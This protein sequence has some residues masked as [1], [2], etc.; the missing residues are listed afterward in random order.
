MIKNH[1]GANF[2]SHSVDQSDKVR[3]LMAVSEADVVCPIDWTGCLAWSSVKSMLSTVPPILYL[4]FRVFSL[5][6]ADADERDWY[7]EKEQEAVEQACMVVALSEKDKGVLSQLM[8]GRVIPVEVLLPPLRGDMKQLAS[9]NY[10]DLKQYMPENVT[11]ALTNRPPES[12]CL[13]TCIAR[14]SPEKHIENFVKFVEAN[15]ELFKQHDWIPLLAGSAADQDYANKIQESLLQA[16]PNAI[17]MKSFLTPKALSA[18][19]SRAVVNVHPCEYDAF[20]MTICEAA[21]MGVPSL[22]ESSGNVG[23]SAIVGDG[24]SIEIDISQ[25]Q[26]SSEALTS[27]LNDEQGLK[28]IGEEAKKRALTWDEAA[29]GKKLL[30]YLHEVRQ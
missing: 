3:L 11:S 16:T 2:A 17:I 27:I 19:L 20:G 14:L 5:G 15:R 28:G 10:K 22:V 9:L 13:V 23:A 21:A 8:K 24:A 1:P 6:I 12:K 29:Y 7:M 4:N 30:E 25:G 26:Y 18:V